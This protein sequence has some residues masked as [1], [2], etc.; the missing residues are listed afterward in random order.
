MFANMEHLY[1]RLHMPNI[2]IKFNIKRSATEK[3]TGATPQTIYHQS[4]RLG[5]IKWKI[6]GC[7]NLLHARLIM[8]EC[9]E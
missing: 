4:T 6:V 2:I 5:H 3:Q 1:V 9:L 8:Y 7:K